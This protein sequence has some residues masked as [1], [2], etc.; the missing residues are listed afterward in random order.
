MTDRLWRGVLDDGTEVLITGWAHTDGREVLEMA[1][2]RIGE[3]SWGMPV[4]LI[5]EIDA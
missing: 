1:L 4:V 3:R 2:R 5:E